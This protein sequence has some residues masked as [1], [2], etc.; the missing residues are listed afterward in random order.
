MAATQTGATG[1]HTR[2]TH[3]AHGLTGKVI[4]GAGKGTGG[5]VTILILVQML[6]HL[7][8]DRRKAS[9]GVLAPS[10]CRRR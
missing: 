2:A 4:A 1:C 3:L 9:A 5:M 8:K 6:G 10:L 7:H